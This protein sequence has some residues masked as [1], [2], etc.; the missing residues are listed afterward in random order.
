MAYTLQNV[1][2]RARYPLNDDAKERYTDAQLLAFTL[3]ALNE[4]LRVRPDLFLPTFAVTVT[5]LGH[6]FPLAD[7]FMQAVADYVTCRA[8]LTDDEFTANGKAREFL[9]LSL[10]SMT[11]GQ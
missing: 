3:T 8:S 10:G 9:L 5:A 2:D 4:L 6:T 11:G 1:V 7:P